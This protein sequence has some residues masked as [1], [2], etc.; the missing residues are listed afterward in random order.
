[1]MVPPQVLRIIIIIEKLMFSLNH[2]KLLTVADKPHPLSRGR[3]NPSKGPTNA[4]LEIIIIMQCYNLY[5]LIIEK[6]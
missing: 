4:N 5:N 3:G 1:M 2:Y 6:D